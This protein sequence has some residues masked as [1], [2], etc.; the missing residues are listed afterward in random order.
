MGAHQQAIAKFYQVMNHSLSLKLDRFDYYQGLVAKAQTEVAD[1]FY[2]QGKYPEAVEYFNRLLKLESKSLD[3]AS[4]HFK[5]VRS[6][7]AMQGYDRLVGQAQSFVQLYPDNS[8]VGE[9]RFLL[10]DALKKLGRNRESMQQVMTLLQTQQKQSESHPE[11]WAYWQQRT[12]NEI[13]NELYKEGDYMSALEI[14]LGL[15]NLNSAASW[16]LPVWYQIG[17][18]YEHLKQ[19]AKATEMYDQILKRQVEV[20]GN[21]PS[22]SLISLL[23]MAQWR[24][25]YIQWGKQAD[26]SVEKLHL[27]PATPGKEA[28]VTDKERAA[29]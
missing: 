28:P 19:P 26:D 24:R 10:A 14:Y 1:T 13:A 22:Q 27:P 6:L 15:A 4:V 29:N 21:A 12:G 16:Q 20:R 18:V 23:D 2:L 7:A 25:N 5:L 11:V 17:L 8:D 3:R 9:V